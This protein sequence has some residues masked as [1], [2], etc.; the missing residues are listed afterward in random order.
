MKKCP[1]CGHQVSSTARSCPQCGD[2]L[3]ARS[4]WWWA[5]LI[6]LAMS[7]AWF[8]SLKD[9]DDFE[10]P[11]DSVAMPAASVAPRP[12]ES[13][14][15]LSEPISADALIHVASEYRDDVAQMANLLRERHPHCRDQ[16]DPLN[17]ALSSQQDN[18]ANPRFFAQ[19]GRGAAPVVVHFT[20]MDAVNKT[21]PA[22]PVR[23]PTIS[24]SA[25]A[26]ACES[27]A[28]KEA[29]HP[30][31]VEFSR[32]WDAAFRE[33]EDGSALYASRFSAQ[34]AFGVEQRFDI[35]CRFQGQTIS[36][37]E[38]TLTDE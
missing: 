25:A 34:N 23:A 1:A 5:L 17:I 35:R 19:C 33:R 8:S 13:K 32:V 30:T 22:E 14:S 26:S 38:I 29:S 16:L 20:W 28:R 7:V 36:E 2:N 4:T 31:T 21:L 6:C 9:Q 11:S 24:R 3:A 15:R 18:P 27:A 37:L 12:V 10:T